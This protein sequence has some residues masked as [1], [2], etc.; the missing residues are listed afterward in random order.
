MNTAASPVRF[1][2]FLIALLLLCGVMA[3]T[4]VA[5]EK[6]TFTDLA[7]REVTLET[8][9]KSVVLAGWT[10]SGNPFYTLIALLG[11]DAPKLIVGMDHGLQRYR[12]WI[13]QQFADR[14]PALEKIPDVG[15]PPEINVELIISLKPDVVM[16]PASAV[17]P[18]D[19]SVQTLEKAGIA[20]VMNDFHTESMDT[21]VRSIELIGAIVGK[22]E[23]AQ[24]LIDFYKKQYSVVADRL[25]NVSETAPRVYIELGQD[26]NEYRNTYGK[27]MWGVLAEHARGDNIAAGLVENYGPISPEAVLS[28][29]PQVIILTGANW[30]N[31]PDSLQLGYQADPADSLKRLE[32]FLDRPGWDSLEAVKSR[33]IYGIH[34]GLAREVWDFY[35]LQ[36]FAK[37]FYPE[38]FQD[39]EPLDAFKEFHEKF[40]GLEYRGTWAIGLD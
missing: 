31:K 38:L 30:P 33:K 14:Y 1:P 8:P 39:I 4:A 17:K 21:H 32:K 18:G 9:V 23:R 3:S 29:N 7:G 20:V 12:H 24:E 6:T 13:W 37:W 28:A 16:L 2:L 25:A 19:E 34:H 36:C 22:P 27:S 35:P 40:L 5:A 10:G 11:D 26:P 15:A